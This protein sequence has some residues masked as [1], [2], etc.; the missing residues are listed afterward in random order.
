M[1]TN[2]VI[3]RES[4]KQMEMEAPTS[5]H[6][7]RNFGSMCFRREVITQ[8]D[9]TVQTVEEKDWKRLRY[10]DVKRCVS[11][12]QQGSAKASRGREGDT[13]LC[14]NKTR[15]RL[16]PRTED[17]QTSVRNKGCLSSRESEKLK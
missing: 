17:A 5:R 2:D 14:T 13:C 15:K 1:S 8:K 10:Y 16:E 7:R 4:Y 12:H 11:A 9:E 3:N 6:H